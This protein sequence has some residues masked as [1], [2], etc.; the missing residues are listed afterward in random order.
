M[1]IINKIIPFSCV[2]GLGNRM[3]IFFQGCNYRC[4][5]CHNPETINKC[6]N[7]GVCVSNCGSNALFIENDKV[8]WDKDECINCD[9]C[10]KI[11]PNLASPKVKDYSVEELFKEIENVR[12]FIDGI[13][14]SGGECT[15][16]SEFLI[17]LFKKVKELD[18][19]CYID[20]NGSYNI[21]S[22]KELLE[23]ADKVMLDVKAIDDLEHIKLTGK[24]N[25]IALENLRELM[26]L[27]KLYEVRTVIAPGLNNE[28]TVSKVGSLVKDN[29]RY[30]LIKYREFGVREEGIK[31]HGNKGISLEYINKLKEIAIKSGCSNTIIT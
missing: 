17:E 18:L 8:I 15:L 28:Y 2:D 25:K 5:Y 14:V 24:S 12:F 19:T 26:K 29:C 3:T 31:V 20:T 13:T 1:A 9:K 10:I 27:N 22:N 16:N 30:K 7:C 6:N 11:C 4:T 21:S 23:V